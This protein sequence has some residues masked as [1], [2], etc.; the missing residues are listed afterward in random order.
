[1]VLPKSTSSTG[2]M[3]NIEIVLKKAYKILYITFH[4]ICDLYGLV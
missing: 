1:L 2:K 3:V 4:T